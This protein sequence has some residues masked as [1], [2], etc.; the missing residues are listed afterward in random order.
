MATY[1]WQWF[2]PYPREALWPRVSDTNWINKHAGLPPV[3]YE[4][5]PLPTGGSRTKA[6]AR[7][8]A[9]Q[10]AWYEPPFDWSA[11]EYYAI[12]RRY[13]DG[14]LRL[15]K[16]KTTL[17]DVDGG[18]RIEMVVEMQPRSTLWNV[19]VPILAW[20]GRRGAQRAFRAAAAECV[21]SPAQPEAKA[22]PHLFARAYLRAAGF[23]DALL[24]KL[25]YFLDAAEESELA[26]MRPYA[27]AD[28]WGEPRDLV[29]KLFLSAVRAGMLNLTWDTLCGNCR[30]TKQS[31]QTLAELQRDGHCDACN[32]QFGADFD[33]SV[34]VTFNAHPL[35]KGLNV[36]VYCMVGPH[37]SRF[38]HAQE[39]IRPGGS[40]ELRTALPDGRYVANA[41]TVSRL[42]FSVS[43]KDEQDKVPLSITA[44]GIGGLPA[45]LTAKQL[46][47]ALSNTLDREVLVRI[48][49]SEWPDTIATAADVT[50]MQAFRDLFSSEALKTGLELSI[51]SMTVLFTDLVGS[52]KLYSTSGD[53]P[54]FRIVNDHF[55]QMRAIVERYDGA[56]VKTIGDAI[57][58]V[59][60]D[61]GNALE[62]ALRL[63]EAVGMVEWE[64]GRLGLRVGFHAG[65]C[66]AMTANERLDYFGTTVNLASRLEHTAGAGEISFSESVAAFPHLKAVL[67]KYDLQ[68]VREEI[69]I[70]GFEHPIGV[71]RVR[72]FNVP[73]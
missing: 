5:Q 15:F 45:I 26:K 19:L 68:P 59:F 21:Q 3:T 22:A 56:I 66:I 33:R 44:D 70:K 58:A 4:Y 32:M 72:A 69:A 54:A 7:A 13:I 39:R 6:T 18:T 55:D 12:E 17:V 47:F 14:P 62:A 2:F 63:P 31:V 42:P 61:S 29:L 49:D 24:D 30:G 51:Q 20:Y 25:A 1:M 34:E 60:R 67:A 38:V 43:A 53:A 65:P 73:S 11:P 10:L 41:M 28:R 64:G 50:A 23:S 37:E 46:S 52:T 57:M 16:S 35:G 27:I 48:E 40:G 9:L 71:L 8:G 36:P